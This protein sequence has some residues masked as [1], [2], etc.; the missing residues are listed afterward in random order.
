MPS[1]VNHLPAASRAGVERFLREEQRIWDKMPDWA[2]PMPGDPSF[3][4]VTFDASASLKEMLDV[5]VK[6][7]ERAKVPQE[8]AS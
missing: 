7:Q 3:F 4:V 8:K 2:L 5:L 6:A 1:T